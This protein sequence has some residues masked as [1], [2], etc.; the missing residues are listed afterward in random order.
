M[1][2]AVTVAVV[3]GVEVEVG[4]DPVVFG[5]VGVVVCVLFSNRSVRAV[6]VDIIDD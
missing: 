6:R 2:I 4:C 5:F 1:F 3:E